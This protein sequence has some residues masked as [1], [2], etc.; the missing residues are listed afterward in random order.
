MLSLSDI[1]SSLLEI[2]DVL[3]TT[4]FIEDVNMKN[5]FVPFIVGFAG[6]ISAADNWIASLLL[7]SISNSFHITVSVASIVLTAYLIPYGFMQPIYGFFGDRHGKKKVLSIL[8]FLLSVSTFL[9]SIVDSFVLLVIFRFI[10]GFFA[11]GII[12]ISLGILSDFFENEYL[13]KVISLFLGIVFLGQG[14][15]SAIGG[16]LIG[17]IDWTD[18]FLI[19]SFLSIVSCI[20]T[21][22]IPSVS[23][24]TSNNRFFQSMGSLLRN[25]KLIRLYSLAFCNGFI[26]LG[27]YSFIGSYLFH[28]LQI[29]YDYVGVG[30]M[31]FGLVCFISGLLNQI[32]LSKLS[33]EFVLNM[34]FLF[35][36]CSFLFLSFQQL[37]MAYIGILMLGLGYI[38]VQSVLAS[39]ALALANTQKGLSAGLIGVGIFGGGG[40]GTYMG[41]EVLNNFG[42]SILF[43]SFAGLILIPVIG[44]NIGKI[45]FRHI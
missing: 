19:F 9:C 17:T 42:Y 32:Y 10:T 40:L 35:S 33:K 2:F 14:I 25:K 26:V 12:S 44:C 29:S 21:Y 38:W 4:T 8:M 34:G 3:M 28:G 39:Q 41:G 1:K 15:S 23:V 37:T 43:L 5:Y 7:P 20:L 30:L 11:A 31:L 18:I 24:V 16:W 45:R 13:T 22:F 6:F 27:G 36:F